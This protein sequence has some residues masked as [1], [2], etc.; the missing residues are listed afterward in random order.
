MNSPFSDGQHSDV[1]ASMLSLRFAGWVRSRRNM[2]ARR[3]YRARVEAVRRA[4][5]PS[6]E[7]IES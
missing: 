2:M 3:R 6:R 5:Q 7:L 1:F 4:K